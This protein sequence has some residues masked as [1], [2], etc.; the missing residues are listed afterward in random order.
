MVVENTRVLFGE[1]DLSRDAIL[2]QFDHFANSLW[3]QDVCTGLVSGYLWRCHRLLLFRAVGPFGMGWL[4]IGGVKTDFATDDGQEGIRATGKTGSGTAAGPEG[5]R[6]V[7]NG[8][9]CL[10]RLGGHRFYCAPILVA[11]SDA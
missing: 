10:F 4:Y 6:L 7:L 3:K 11:G 5:C 2:E 8:V 9:V 1:L